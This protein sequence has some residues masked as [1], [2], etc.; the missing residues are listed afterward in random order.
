[1]H[2]RCMGMSTQS[3][4]GVGVCFVFNPTSVFIG[5]PNKRG[6]VAGRELLSNVMPG[7]FAKQR[8]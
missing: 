5:L 3:S 2:C 4:V 1:M 8:A 7:Q 6:H